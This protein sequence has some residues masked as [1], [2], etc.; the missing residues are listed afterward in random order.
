M[1]RTRRVAK[2]PFTSLCVAAT[3]LSTS[4][5]VG[6]PVVSAAAQAEAPQL[7]FLNP[8]SFSARP[9]VGILVGDR[10]PSRPRAGSNT[11]RITAW[12]S[13]VPANGGMEFELLQSGVS[14]ET[15]DPV[16][17]EVDANTYQA[18]WNIPDTLPDGTYTLRAT[19]FENNEAVTNVDQGIVLS[20]VAD[21]VE[22]TYPTTRSQDPFISDGSFGTYAPLA[23][24][25]P[26][27]EAAVRGLPVGNIE[28]N[29]TG[30]APG[31]GTSYVSAFYTISA[32]GTEPEWIACG[33]E[34]AQGTSTL[35][36]AAHNGVRCTLQAP[37]HQTMV[38]AVAAA[39]NTSPENA[40]DPSFNGVGDATR[41]A[42]P[43]AQTP[44]SFSWVDPSAT[45][46]T[47]DQGNE[48]TYACHVASTHLADQVGREILGANIDVHAS[49]PTDKLRMDTGLLPESDLQ[50]PDRHPQ[51][52][53]P[54]YDCWAG[55]DETVGDQADHQILG[56]P[57]IKHIESDRAGTDDTGRWGF[58]FW[59]PADAVSD[60]R[61]TTRFSA[62]VD[63]TDDGCLTNDDRY[64]HGELVVDGIVGFGR[65]PSS[66]QPFAPS[67]LIGC[68]PPLDGPAP[69][70]VVLSSDRNHVK[71]GDQVHL[72]GSVIS[73]Y[74]SCVAEQTVKLKWRRPDRRFSAFT[75]VGS[76]A[77]GTFEAYVTPKKGRNEYRAVAT[78]TETCQRAASE[79]VRVKAYEID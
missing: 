23:T 40:F 22:I 37:E 66:P 46:V 6:G 33:R 4:L 57:D 35:S 32:P 79:V 63:E 75:T 31:S 55:N 47:I 20:R 21:R 29:N 19:L 71:S 34:K 14:L 9:N 69:R 48:G 27:K 28:N 50:V 10:A 7:A 51:A 39:A 49:G 53:E 15:I 43:Y 38:T 17:L 59:T 42:R 5:I 54:G 52:L 24:A 41:V 78:P 67:T 26:E 74:V 56:G 44:T 77:D 12:T 1:R 62:W 72:T 68:M 73:D 8:S 65:A 13:T 70:H 45:G 64:T 60:E 16:A 36:S 25:L 58:S 76:N 2:R 30:N 61:F 3:A 18:E 11:Y